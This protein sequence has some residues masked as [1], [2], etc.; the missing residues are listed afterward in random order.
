MTLHR[1]FS[2]GKGSKKATHFDS[3]I[4]GVGV[5]QNLTFTTNAEPDIQSRIEGG[6]LY[7]NRFVPFQN[8]NQNQNTALGGE[9]EPI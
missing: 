6:T 7:Q 4:L 9:G 3:A 1:G 2:E 5:E 8:Q